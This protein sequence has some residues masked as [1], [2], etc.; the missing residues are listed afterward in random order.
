MTTLLNVLRQI[1]RTGIRAIRILKSQY[2]SLGIL[3][4]RRIAVLAAANVLDTMSATVFVPLLPSLAEELGA[5]AVV[6]GLIFTVPAVVSAVFKAPAGYLS[7][8]IGRR[9]LISIGVTASALP[10]IAIAFAWSP[11]VLIVLRSVD[12]LLRAFVGP[13]TTAYLGDT[14]D[15]D[16][17]GEA[18][19]AYHT[20]SMIGAAAGPALGGSIAEFG[21]IRLPFLVLGAG[22]LV[23][24]FTLLAFLPAIEGQSDT[25]GAGT[26]GILP[27]VSRNS[28][29]VF[30]SVPAVAWLVT[31]S[32]DEFG[33]NALNPTFPLLLQETVGRGPAYVGTTY[34]ALALAMLVFLPIGGRVSDRIGRIQVLLV[35]YVGWC[36]VMIGLAVAT[37]PFI[38]PVLMFVGGV[39]SAFAAPA[40][41]ALRYE[42][43]PDGREGTFSGITGAAESIGK[44]T[45]PMFAGVIMGLWGVRIAVIAAGISWLAA[46]PLLAFFVPRGSDAS[47]TSPS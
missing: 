44:A 2:A 35:S 28:I 46:V 17:R 30:L 24:G 12:A 45:G 27:D 16:N 20:S 6:I 23:G 47:D 26:L 29:G 25:N 32:I 15:A 36:L 42:I 9:P 1:R 39:L 38:P 4:D 21:G 11:L 5:S 3:R 41:F 7:D 8:R 14:Y 19:G 10:V 31:A 13:A 33:S 43:A 40:S 34:S 22:T 18:F 37:T